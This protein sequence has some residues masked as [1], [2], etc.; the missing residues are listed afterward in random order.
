MT[1]H[2]SMA[3][4]IIGNGSHRINR[5]SIE[6]QG[7]IKSGDINDKDEVVITISGA[8]EAVKKA[9]YLLQREIREEEDLCY[10]CLGT[11]HFAGNYSQKEDTY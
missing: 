9:R 1:I 11:G 7:R 3:G 2:K 4:G 8:E 6:S 10:K 5:I